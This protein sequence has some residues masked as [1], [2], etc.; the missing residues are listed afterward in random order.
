MT[1]NGDGTLAR[2]ATN[3]QIIII[4]LTHASMQIAIL[5]FEIILTQTKTPDQKLAFIYQVLYKHCHFWQKFRVFPFWSY[6]D[7]IYLNIKGII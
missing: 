1:L 2:P 4:C 5:Y 6:V 7:L 3:D